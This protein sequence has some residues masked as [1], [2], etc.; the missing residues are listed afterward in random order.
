[1]TG[2]P[3]KN[4][5]RGVAADAACLP[6]AVR[7]SPLISRPR[8]GTSRENSFL[9]SATTT[10][11]AL[12]SYSLSLFPSLAPPISSLFCYPPR[13]AECNLGSCR[14]AML[15]PLSLPRMN[16]KEPLLPSRNT[17]NSES[18]LFIL[19]ILGILPI[20]IAQSTPFLQLSSS[21][22]PDLFL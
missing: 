8:S 21:F 20:F 3:T 2:A 7:F 13:S 6:A 17:P 18:Q 15:P 14:Q 4:P 1:M 16:E 10:L 22:S 12:F 5:L 11:L 9:R 19:G